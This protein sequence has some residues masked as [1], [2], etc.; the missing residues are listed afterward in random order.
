[1]IVAEQDAV[2]PMSLARSAFDRA[3]EPEDFIALACSHTAV[4]DTEPFLS[5]AADAAIGRYGKNLAP[6]LSAAER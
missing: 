4:Y 3:G 1:M 6:P 2:I 5:E